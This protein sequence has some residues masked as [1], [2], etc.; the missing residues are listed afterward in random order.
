MHEP[1]ALVRPPHFLREWREARGL[2]LADMARLTPFGKSTLSRVE[3]GRL[4]YYAAILDAYARVIGC[5]PYALLHRPPGGPEEL[6]T[7]VD[8]LVEKLTGGLKT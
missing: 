6:F 2:S 8:E 5:K 1:V 4:G 3:T 7:F